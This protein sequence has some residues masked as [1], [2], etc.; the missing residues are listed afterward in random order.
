MGNFCF[1]CLNPVTGLKGQNIYEGDPGFAKGDILPANHTSIAP[2]FNF[3]WSPFTNRKT[4]IRGG[5]DIFYS[6]AIENINAPGQSV[7][8]VGYRYQRDVLSQAEVSSSWPVSEA[9][10]MLFTC[11]MRQSPAA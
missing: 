7:V 3:S 11:A 4:V 9:P 2:R 10:S 1:T 8:N 6:D 5:Y